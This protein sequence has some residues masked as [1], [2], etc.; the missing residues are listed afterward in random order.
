MS[1]TRLLLTTGVLLLL[2]ASNHGLDAAKPTSD[3][4]LTVT[5]G[6]ALTDGLRSDDGIYVSGTQN[7][8]A[9]LLSNSNGNFIFDTNNAA[10]FDG[11]RRLVIHF[12][13]PPPSPLAQTFS[14]DVFLGTLATDSSPT[15]NLRTMSAGQTFPRR[16]RVSW[17]QGSTQYSLAWNGNLDGHNHGYVNFLCDIGTSCTQWT[18]TPSGTAGLYSIPTKGNSSETYIGTYTMPF[19]MTLTR[20]P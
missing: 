8:K 15:S 6:D 2:A 3:V 17:V 10:A 1:H 4:P 14:A 11:L 16:T 20:N 13:T 5:L 12:P 18:V 9:V 19:S 7:V